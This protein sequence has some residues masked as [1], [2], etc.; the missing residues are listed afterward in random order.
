MDFGEVFVIIN[1][2]VAEVYAQRMEL[3]RGKWRLKVQILVIFGFFFNIR[4][5]QPCSHRPAGSRKDTGVL[6]IGA[7]DTE[8]PY[9][10]HSA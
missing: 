7:L 8:T 9:T 10:A 4:D 3:F 5:P 2:Y 1:P 6:D